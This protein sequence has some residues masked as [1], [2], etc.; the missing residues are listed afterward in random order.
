[1][2]RATA[3]NPEESEVTCHHRHHIDVISIVFIIGIVIVI[4]VM[5][6][7]EISIIIV[8]FGSSSS[9]WPR[10]HPP[11]ISPSL[12]SANRCGPSPLG[13]SWRRAMDPAL[14]AALLP[15]AP[16][17]RLSGLGAKLATAGVVDCRALADLLRMDAYEFISDFFNLED[18]FTEAEFAILEGCAQKVGIGPVVLKRVRAAD[19]HADDVVEV[20]LAKKKKTEESMNAMDDPPPLPGLKMGLRRFARKPD[21]SA[22]D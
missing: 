1:M 19:I 8:N 20:L 18:A 16:S 3:T 6:M 12:G 17:P 10:S 11:Q 22:L 21:G 2:L 9:S 13:S 4:V 5:M 7:I 15:L 14:A